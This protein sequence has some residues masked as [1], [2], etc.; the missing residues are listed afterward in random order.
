MLKLLILGAVLRRAPTGGIARF[1]ALTAAIAAF[2]VA[3][4]PSDAFA[5]EPLFECVSSDSTFQLRLVRRSRMVTLERAL[6]ILKRKTRL[7]R[8][9][10][11]GAK[12]D[13]PRVGGLKRRMRWLRDQKRG[14]SSCS[15]EQ[16]TP[17]EPTEE[18]PIVNKKPTTLP[19]ISRETYRAAQLFLDLGLPEQEGVTPTYSI[20]EPPEHGVLVERPRAV[21]Y[22]PS[23]DFVGSESFRYQIQAPDSDWLEG[24][25][26]ITVLPLPNEPTPVPAPPEVLIQRADGSSEIISV[27][28]KRADVWKRTSDSS[29]A[30]L[31]R[32]H[33]ELRWTLTLTN[34]SASE[35]TAV[36]F[37]WQS[38]EDEHREILQPYLMGVSVQ[39]NHDSPWQ[40]KSLVYPGGVGAP[41][42]ISDFGD[43]R[44]K[45]LAAT[46]FPPKRVKV[47]NSRGRV[48]LQYTDRVPFGDSVELS[49]LTAEATDDPGRGI[50]AWHLLTD[51][52]REWLEAA[53]EQAGKIQ[54]YP[55]WLRRADGFLNFQLENMH[56]FDVAAVQDHWNQWRHLFPWMQFWGQM[57][58]YSG[59]PEYSCEPPGPN[60]DVGCCVLNPDLHS[61][62]SPDLI[63]FIEEE[64]PTGGVFGFYTRSFSKIELTEEELDL[65]TVEEYLLPIQNWLAQNQVLYGT[66]ASYID[67]IARTSPALVDPSAVMEYLWNSFPE[68][69]MNEGIVDIYPQAALTSGALDAGT[70]FN[71]EL[72]I[73]LM[74]FIAPSKKYFLGYSNGGYLH[75]YS[76]SDFE[77]ERAVFLH[78]LGFDVN[79]PGEP[80]DRSIL[81]RHLA[82]TISERERV[83]WYDW[84]L[85]GPRYRDTWGI[86]LVPDGV[87]VRRFQGAGGTV[88]AIDNE[89][90]LPT[91]EFKLDGRKLQVEAPRSPVDEH[92]ELMFLVSNP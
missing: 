74:P 6:K 11:R 72:E 13:I 22:V 83:G 43:G 18:A 44:A 86:T 30:T 87:E 66:N 54:T 57:S 4:F 29:S 71:G 15:S 51:L 67:V 28:D 50:K 12:R 76:V 19:P 70:I 88:L 55:E 17:E 42:I 31:T 90:R 52:Y 59:P 58:T 92:P 53:M 61:R 65:L 40:W 80:S 60:E 2:V 23:T 75:E 82:L 26:E 85:V 49:H 89:A 24:K 91:I 35:I 16:P 46:N 69:T 27:W 73:G 63:N 39:N 32:S 3:V 1:F 9:R 81:R 64:R 8:R 5:R 62:Y 33:D 68:N 38:E 21:I 48:S 36:W 84:G 45:V 34:I 47:M 56:C 78:G 79:N 37:P 25:V 77:S 41:L 7:T 20:L 10:I 14:I